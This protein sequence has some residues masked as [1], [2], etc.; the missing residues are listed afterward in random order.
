MASPSFKPT[1]AILPFTEETIAARAHEIFLRDGSVDG[2]DEQNWFKAIEE[3]TAERQIE[4]G[5]PPDS[6]LVV[7]GRMP[8]RAVPRGRR[9]GDS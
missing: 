8:S 2:I 5:K 9:V 4:S 3:L 1:P 6:T 7:T